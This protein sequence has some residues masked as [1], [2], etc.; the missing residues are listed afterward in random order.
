MR[1]FLKPTVLFC[2]V[3]CCTLS[4]S[5]QDKAPHNLL[6]RV[7]AGN[8]ISLKHFS[9]EETSF[10]IPGSS[11]V[12]LQLATNLIEKNNKSLF[13]G[14]E[15]QALN[16]YPTTTEKASL[17]YVSVLVGRTMRVDVNQGL[18]LKYTG[19]LSLGTLADVA[20]SVSGYGSYS[21]GPA[22]NINLGAFNNLQVLFTG[23]KKNNRLD[24]GLGFDVVINGVPVYSSRSYPSYLK[25]NGFIQYGLGFVVNYN[26]QGSNQNLE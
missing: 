12:N 5:G 14:L 8:S 13:I 3:H 11:F 20:S 1:P 25:N 24:F 7:G 21:G 16:Y 9:Q 10:N 4:G 17:T 2:L 19:G 23:A 26:I 18:Y 6:V 15:M 22:K